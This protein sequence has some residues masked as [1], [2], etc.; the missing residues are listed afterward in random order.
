MYH[1]PGPN[2]PTL[3]QLQDQLLNLDGDSQKQQEIKSEDF[4][5]KDAG[6]SEVGLCFVLKI[7]KKCTK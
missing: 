6:S 4:F 5:M 3:E 7:Q 2:T 1:S